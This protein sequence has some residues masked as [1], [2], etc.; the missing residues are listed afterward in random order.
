MRDL[1]SLL[2]R[3]PPP[4]EPWYGRDG[5]ERFRSDR[6]LV[7][8][9]FPRIRHLIDPLA[10]RVFLEGELV[11]RGDAGVPERVAVRVEFGDGYP[12]YEPSAYEPV[13]RFPRIA[14]RHLYPD[15]RCCLWIEQE[16]RWDGGDPEGLRRF[17]DEVALFFDRQLICD[18]TGS[19]PGPQRGHGVDG[20]VEFA[21]DVLGGDAVLAAMLPLLCGRKTVAG[22]DRCPCGS[23]RR[24]RRCHEPAVA[25]VF[26]NVDRR[27]MQGEFRSWSRPAASAAC[28]GGQTRC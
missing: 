8:S 5:G 2:S 11:I 28:C 19:F 20:Y 18:L 21:R 27:W 3:T 12:A 6:D 10:H 13:G 7:R 14:D 4:G 25:R 24:F 17:L 26:R 9:Q 16:S 1:S 23:G 15:G 22:G